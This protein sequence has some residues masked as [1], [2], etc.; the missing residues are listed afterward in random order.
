M[1]SSV[2]PQADSRGAAAIEVCGNVAIRPPRQSM[3]TETV[4]TEFPDL[5]FLSFRPTLGYSRRICS[6]AWGRLF[7]DLQVAVSAPASRRKRGVGESPLFVCSKIRTVFSP[8]TALQPQL[9]PCNWTQSAPPPTA[10][11]PSTERLSPSPSP[12]SSKRA[13]RRKPSPPRSPR[14][15]SATSR[16]PTWSPKYKAV[17][18]NSKL[19][20]DDSKLELDPHYRNTRNE[21]TPWQVCCINRSKC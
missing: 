14:F 12:P 17:G 5:N 7:R 2:M 9:W 13:S 6:A 19:K 3:L 16:R 4:P 15:P 21:K 1:R 8:P 11:P 10:S 18:K 20:T